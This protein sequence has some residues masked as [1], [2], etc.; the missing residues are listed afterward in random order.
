M[1]ATAAEFSVLVRTQGGK[2]RAGVL[3]LL[4]L[5]FRVFSLG[6]RSEFVLFANFTPKLWRHMWEASN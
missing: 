4:V 5:F 3:K 1:A 2:R 6:T